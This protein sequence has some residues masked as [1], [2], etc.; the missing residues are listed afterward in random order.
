MPFKPDQYSHGFGHKWFAEGKAINLIY[1]DLSK[2]FDSVNH[3]L[4]LA[5]LRGYGITL[6]VL[7]WVESFQ[8]NVNG[9]LYQTAE[10]II[11]VS[12]SVIGPILFV[13]YA[14]NLPDHHLQTASSMQMRSTSSPPVTAMIF[15]ETP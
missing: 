6:I 1:L 4:I 9:A 14:N 8:V 15:S 7:V 2:A 11:G 3:R 13:L 5:N 12:H 10:A